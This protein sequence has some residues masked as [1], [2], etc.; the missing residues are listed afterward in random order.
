MNKFPFLIDMNYQL[1]YYKY[2][3]RYL[4][5][6]GGEEIDEHILD[7][8]KISNSNHHF[9]LDFFNNLDSSTVIF[10][11]LG[12]IFSLALIQLASRG[13]SEEELF[14][15]L[16]YQYTIDDLKAIYQTFNISNLL[17]INNNQRINKDYI[18]MIRKICVVIHDN[19][20][21]DVIM[22]INKYISKRTHGFIDSM[23]HPS[24]IDSNSK[25]ILT[26]TIYFSS[27]WNHK[28]NPKNTTKMKFH[29]DKYD[30]VDMMHQIG[31]FSYYENKSI[32]LI[33][34]PYE[35]QNYVMGIILPKE[36]LQETNH[37][38]TINNI[39]LFTTN[40]INEFIDNLSNTYIDLYL[41]KFSSKKRFEIK[42][43]LEKMGLFSIFHKNFDIDILETESWVSNI[44]H[45]SFIQIDENGTIATAATSVIIKSSIIFNP[46]TK[47]ILFKADHVFVYYIRYV[48]SN[49]FLFYGTYQGA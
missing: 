18:Q 30:T 41:P 20:N 37:D 11:P 9:T 23:I 7:N 26:N 40:E 32:Q 47:P 44:I 5:Q 1:K 8:T 39:P 34:L 19:I 16:K 49:I 2:R 22:E 17:I 15:I 6:K 14:K 24:D 3:F 35:N 25:L 46:I 13:K 42:S 29:H 45:E 28:F 21:S 38:Y 33:E 27:Q 10:S 43:I 48:P 31:H 12:I 36:Y 4:L